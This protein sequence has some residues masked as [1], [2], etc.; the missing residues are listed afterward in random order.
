ML[1]LISAEWL[2]KGKLV[3]MAEGD[4]KRGQKKSNEKR[5]HQRKENSARMD[6]YREQ[7]LAG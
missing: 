6:S 5:E 4:R 3:I 1:E 7:N 2:R